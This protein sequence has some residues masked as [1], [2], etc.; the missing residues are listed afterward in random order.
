MSTI[1]HYIDVGQGNMSLLECSGAIRFVVDCNITEDNQDRV[2]S[3]L[4]AQ[5][6]RGSHLRAFICTHRD[7]DHMRGVQILHKHFPLQ[8]IWDSGY[9]GTST[10]ST[11]YDAYMRLR[12][13]VG[14][15]VK[16]RRKY[17]DFGRTRLRFLSAQDQRLPNNAN[18]QGIV[19]K[20]EQLSPST[21]TGKCGTIMTGD[22][23]AATWK[24]GVMKDYSAQDL[25]CDILLASHHGSVTFFDDPAD[26]RNYYTSHIKAMNPAMAIVSVGKNSYGHPDS[27]AIELYEDH[28]RGS[29]KGNK[30]YRTD[31]QGTMKLVLKD[32][33]GWNLK[34]RQK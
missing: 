28:A 29:D 23:D 19:V 21:S 26:E 31:D 12:R 16:E 22:S 24:Y 10:D 20:I 25:S 2:L 18:A 30:V 4:A 8:Q 32:D 9:P 7:A 17:K 14:G 11:E 15:V 6:G 27:K 5:I 1:V 34:V 33:G 3:Y 13:L